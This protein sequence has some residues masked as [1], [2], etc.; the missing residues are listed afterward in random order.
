M[1]LRAD[2][3]PMGDRLRARFFQ[4]IV[5][6]A[7]SSCRRW[8]DLTAAVGGEDLEPYFFGPVEML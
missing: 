8:N 6:P 7:L 4:L 2:L 1:G 3:L 5:D